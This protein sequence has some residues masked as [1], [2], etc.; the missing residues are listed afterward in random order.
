RTDL[1]F[2][3]TEICAAINKL[4]KKV[5]KTFR[6]YFDSSIEMDEKTG[7]MTVVGEVDVSKI[8]WKLRKI[9]TA[10]IVSVEVVK[11]SE[12]KSE[13]EKPATPKPVEIL[14]YPITHLNYPYQCYSSYA[15]SH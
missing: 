4:E 7:K 6:G 12:K 15:N 11:P 1:R 9:C 3:M 14:A 5:G 2:Q 13:P 8:V 10:D